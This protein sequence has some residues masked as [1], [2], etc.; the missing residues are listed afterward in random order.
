M[1]FILSTEHPIGKF[2]PPMY[3]LYKAYCS[4]NNFSEFL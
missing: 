2:Y 3:E 1:M 4:W